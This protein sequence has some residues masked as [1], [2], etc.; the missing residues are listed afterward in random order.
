MSNGLPVSR[1]INVDVNLSPS[2]AQAPNLN[3]LLIIGSSDVIDTQAR[4]VSYTSLADIGAAF[5]ANAPEYGAAAAWFSQRPSPTQVYIGRWAKTATSGLL[6]GG[7]LSAAQQALAN[8]TSVVNGGFKITVDGGSAVNITGLTFPGV[9]N[10]NGV[11]SAINTALTTATV[12]AT[13]AWDGSRFTFKSTATGITSKV[14]PLTAPTAGTNIAPLLNATT[15]LGAREVDGIA[16]ETPIQAVIILDSMPTSAYAYMFAANDMVEADVLAIADYIEAASRKHLFGITTNQPGAID[17]AIDT[18][19]I[20]V[21]S[22]GGYNRSIAQFSSSSAYAVASLFGRIL[23]TDF[24]ANNSMIT[25][26]YKQQPGISPEQLT[27]PQADA[28]MNKHGNVFVAYDN[29]TAII[30][31]GTVASGLFIDEVYGTDWLK[32]RI[33]VDLYNALYTTPTKIPQTDQGMGI[34]ATVIEGSLS[35]SVNNGLVAPGVWNSGGFGI[36][37]TGDFLPAGFYVYSPPIGLQSVADRAARK[38]VAFVVA[39][40][41]AGA[42]HTVDVLVNIDR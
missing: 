42:V 33:E 15:A 41:L 31:Y 11:A 38:S 25:L 14:A 2:A 5:G 12:P 35:A 7:A 24:N 30:Q 9:T 21:L 3:S 1:L 34:L 26:M 39:A 27:T 8:F 28:L 18:D 29:D 32:Y 17:P 19:I 4:I 36:L 10:L 20:S 22:N 13:V 16:A 6:I 37:K 23:T 40:K